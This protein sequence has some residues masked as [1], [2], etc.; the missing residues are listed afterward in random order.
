LGLEHRLFDQLLLLVQDRRQASVDDLLASLAGSFANLTVCEH[1]ESRLPVKLHDK[2]QDA[3]AEE[4]VQ[5]L[6]SDIKD[7]PK[8]HDRDEDKRKLFLILSR[9]PDDNLVNRFV[10]AQQLEDLDN[11][12]TCRTIQS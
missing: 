7:M 2:K 8:T 9:L 1:A 12:V 4:L 6:V 11:N 5:E 10:V 3:M